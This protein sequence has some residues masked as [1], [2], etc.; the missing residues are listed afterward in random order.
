MR[1]IV[2]VGGGLAG[3]AAAIKIRRYSQMEV[4][5]LEQGVS[6]ANRLDN[7]SERVVGMGG[8]GTLAGGKLC[9]PPASSGAWSKGRFSKKRFANFLEEWAGFLPLDVFD[10][11]VMPF[12]H[13]DTIYYK[14]YR[15]QL[16]CKSEMSRCV[17]GFVGELESCG[18]DMRLETK[19]KRIVP[20]NRCHMLDLRSRDGRHS[21]LAADSVIIATG[22]SSAFEIERVLPT[23]VRINEQSLDL[24]FRFTAPRSEVPVFSLLGNDVK[25]KANYGGVSVRTFCVCSGGEATLVD[26]GGLTYAD[27]HF[28]EVLTEQ[29]NIGILGRHGALRGEKA[30]WAFHE[31]AETLF[32]DADTLGS[33][34]SI[35]ERFSEGGPMSELFRAFSEYINELLRIGVLGKN[36]ADYPVQIPSMDRLNPIVT[37]DESFMTDVNDLYVIGDASGSSRGFLQALWGGN[38]AAERILEKELWRQS[39]TAEALY[40]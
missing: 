30:A 5:L 1:R 37:T 11:A 40:I 20:T 24:G 39:S 31:L 18:V 10:S 6:Y 9:F 34:L 33:L 26:V 8:A 2:V 27:G 13:S 32:S 3:M 7:P 23:S 15:S 29:V 14:P 36:F 35:F 21:L 16:V 17:H 4:I 25:L 28:G 38:V 12:V 19:V 22:R